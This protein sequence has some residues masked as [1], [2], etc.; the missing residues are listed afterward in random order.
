VT[1]FAHKFQNLHVHMQAESLV[2]WLN[3]SA[4]HLRLY[5]QQAGRVIE[6]LRLPEAKER[7][8]ELEQLIK[9][10]HDLKWR[11]LRDAAGRLYLNQIARD[12]SNYGLVLIA[13]LSEFGLPWVRQCVCGTWF[14]AHSS[15]SRFHSKPCRERFW[16]DQRKS[17][18]GK[19]AHALYMRQLRATKKQLKKSEE[20]KR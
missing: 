3:E 11:I 12:D 17:P 20:K 8:E 1:I 10:L 6:I 15:R 9:P 18:E 14:L 16:E 2:D 4:L 7:R 5:Q 19:K 13:Q